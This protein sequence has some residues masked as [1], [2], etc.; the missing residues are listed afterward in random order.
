MKHTHLVKGLD[1]ALLSKVRT[2]LHDLTEGGDDGGGEGAAGGSGQTALEAAAA[3]GSVT[4]TGI[5]AS[6]AAEMLQQKISAA[7]AAAG[8]GYASILGD[9]FKDGQEAGLSKEAMEDEGRPVEFRNRRTQLLYNRLFP[10]KVT[11]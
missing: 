8:A 3:L 7:A 2:E 5:S 4:T 6:G 1:V 10:D 11:R 9:S